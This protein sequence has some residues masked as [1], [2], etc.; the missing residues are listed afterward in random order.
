MSGNFKCLFLFGH[1]KKISRKWLVLIIDIYTLGAPPPLV[2]ISITHTS[3]FLNITYYIY[4]C[5]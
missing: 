3:Y 5:S 1:D 2:F 4:S